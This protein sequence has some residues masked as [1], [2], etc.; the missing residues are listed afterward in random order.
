MQNIFIPITKEV[1]KID[2][3]GEEITK[4][5]SYKLQFFHSIKFMAIISFSNLVDH[6]AEGT[7]KIKC[8]YRYGN[9]ECD[10]C[11]IKYKDCECCL[12]YADVK[13]DLIELK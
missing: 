3:N 6:L 12:E 4:T 2:K 13:D 1:K 9:K 8:K 11:R 5:T 10:T 7:H